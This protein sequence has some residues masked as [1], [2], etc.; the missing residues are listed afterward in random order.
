ME[1]TAAD[2]ITLRNVLC[3]HMLGFSIK[4]KKGQMGWGRRLCGVHGHLDSRS[5]FA[6]CHLIT[7]TV[8]VLLFA[9]AICCRT[10][11]CLSAI[12]A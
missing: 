5:R 12:E 4:K 11:F 3:I 7:Q 8:Q 9:F 1:W 2:L 6:L 10:T